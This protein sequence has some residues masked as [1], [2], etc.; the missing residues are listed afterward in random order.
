[1]SYTTNSNSIGLEFDTTNWT[2]AENYQSFQLD[3]TSQIARLSRPGTYWLTYCTTAKK[4]TGNASYNSDIAHACLRN[5][6][7]YFKSIAKG[8][9][10]V[11]LSTIKYK[12]DGVWNRFTE[13][14]YIDE[15]A[16]ADAKAGR[17]IGLCLDLMKGKAVQNIYVDQVRLEIAKDVKL[18]S[19]E[20][21]TTWKMAEFTLIGKPAKNYNNYELAITATNTVT[22]TTITQ[23]GFWNGGSE[24]KVRIAFTEAGV[25]N[26]T[27]SGTA[28]ETVQNGTVECVKAS[29]SDHAI[30]QH[31]FVTENGKYFTYADGT[32]FYYVADTHWNIVDEIVEADVAI[33][34]YEADA[35]M[36]SGYKYTG[37]SN[38]VRVHLTKL[39]AETRAKQGYTVIQTQPSGGGSTQL[40]SGIT[41]GITGTDNAIKYFT[42]LDEAFDI[43]ADQGLV[44]ANAQLIF[45]QYMKML[46][47]NYGGMDTSLP[48]AYY[49]TVVTN[50]VGGTPVRISASDFNSIA[51]QNA[52]N[53]K[54]IHETIVGLGVDRYVVFNGSVNDFDNMTEYLVRYDFNDEFYAQMRSVARYW[55][56]RYAAYPSMW[57]LGQEIDNDFYFGRTRED[58]ADVTIIRDGVETVGTAY[59]FL[60]TWN[61]CS[62]TNPY[63]LIAEG[64]AEFDPYS[65]PLTAHQEGAS[66]ASV[67]GGGITDAYYLA[68]DAGKKFSQRTPQ[69]T[70]SAGIYKGNKDSGNSIFLAIKGHSFFGAQVSPCWWNRNAYNYSG[71]YSGDIVI[72]Q[73]YY[74]NSS[75]PAVNY[76]PAYLWLKTN[77]YTMRYRSWYAFMNGWAGFAF[78]ANDTW[79]YKNGYHCYE[80]S[81]DEHNGNITT[82]IKQ[83]ATYID[84]LNSNSGVQMGYINKF[85]TES[86]VSL[87][88]LRPAWGNSS[89]FGAAS[90]DLLWSMMRS[91][92]AAVIYFGDC[93]IN[94]ST[95]HA[96]NNTYGATGFMSTAYKNAAKAKTYFDTTKSLA[97]HDAAVTAA[98]LSDNDKIEISIMRDGGYNLP[99]GNLQ[100]NGSEWYINPDTT[101]RNTNVTGTV[102]GLSNGTYTVGWFNPITGQFVSVGT[103]TVSNGTYAIGE[104]P[105]G[106]DFVFYMVKN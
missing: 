12:G 79:S 61:W 20:K 72:S 37:T 50:G 48:V 14:I 63:I 73:D 55:V 88:S 13:A 25:W 47:P 76:E 98:E 102:K 57:S 93:S 74:N 23:P 24:Y 39:M 30:Y 95:Y 2:N 10:Y 1:M 65:Q 71:Q 8:D 17:S 94:N 81:T 32:P 80:H 77:N 56:A 84:S 44:N 9:S 104:K 83:Y 103:K 36:P 15:A 42:R 105:V 46:I 64:I 91:D 40:L 7:G 19:P 100:S 11:G 53:A 18:A 78:G 28:L 68:S 86:G 101:T 33:A 41:A 5:D 62:L 22:G 59:N 58:K 92:S 52:S 96:T 27:I 35:S 69:T 90:S 51:S 38:K 70:Y 16:I 6:K 21:A 43:I 49:K 3:L 54:I 31:G 89:Y 99:L 85:F 82:E 29:S 4:G 66:G 87:S 60:E 97:V 26:Y 106:H 75:K 45:P 34:G 67:Y